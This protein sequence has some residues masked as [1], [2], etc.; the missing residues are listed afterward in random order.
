M[1]HERALHYPHHFCVLYRTAHTVPKSTRSVFKI[2]TRTDLQYIKS[3]LHYT[4]VLALCSGSGTPL[5]APG[6]LWPGRQIST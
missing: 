5:G 6:A 2:N 4:T 3:T 1:T